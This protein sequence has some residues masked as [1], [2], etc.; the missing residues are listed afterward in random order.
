MV[1]RSV[2]VLD[3]FV[4]AAILVRGIAAN[5]AR[6]FTSGHTQGVQPGLAILCGSTGRATE[7]LLDN[8]AHSRPRE[9]LAT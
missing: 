5:V 3:L 2:A 8:T 1:F 7:T 4:F 6:H 9:S